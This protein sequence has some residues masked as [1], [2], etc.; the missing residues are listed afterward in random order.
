MRCLIRFMRRRCE[1]RSLR[2]IEIIGEGKEGVG[3][4]G[5]CCITLIAICKRIYTFETF[6]HNR[7]RKFL[8]K[9]FYKNQLGY[10]KPKK[11]IDNQMKGRYI[12]YIKIWL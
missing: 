11:V 1:R 9:C 7:N 3:C 2:V 6:K 8:Y 4:Y 5:G 10:E 12:I